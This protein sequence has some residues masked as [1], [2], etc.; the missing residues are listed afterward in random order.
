MTNL[1]L[2][3]FTTDSVMLTFTAPTDS[4]CIAN[5]AITTGASAPPSTTDTSV[6]I[7][8]PGNDAEGVTYSVSVAAVDFA[9]RM[10]ESSSVDCFM[11]SGKSEQIIYFLS[12]ESYSMY[13]LIKFIVYHVGTKN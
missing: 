13:G 2:A 9:G 7:T 12:H 3:D 10:A 11:F 1:V 8:K 6:T 5:Y 4:S